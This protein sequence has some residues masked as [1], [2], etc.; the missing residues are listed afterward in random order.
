MLAIV[1]FFIFLAGSA[2]AYWAESYSGYEKLSEV[3]AGI[4]LMIG[5][6]LLGA[7]LEISLGP[8]GR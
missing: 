3:V 1:G 6:T 8:I 2:L 5:L 7:N 4:L